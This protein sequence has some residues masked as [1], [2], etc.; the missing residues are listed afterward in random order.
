M[1]VGVSCWRVVVGGCGDGSDD[2]SDDEGKDEEN[3]ETGC[4]FSLIVRQVVR[5]RVRRVH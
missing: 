5:S 4:C 1:P 3:G 2:G